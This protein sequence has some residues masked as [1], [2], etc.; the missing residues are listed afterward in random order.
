VRSL[1]RPSAGSGSASSA[2]AFALDDLPRGGD[3]GADACLVGDLG[4]GAAL[5]G[6]LGAGAALVGDLG[7]GAAFVGDLGALVSFDR[8]GLVPGLARD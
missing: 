1:K 2:A 6:D 4:A 3:L 5:V 8:A 7:A